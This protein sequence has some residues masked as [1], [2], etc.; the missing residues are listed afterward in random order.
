MGFYRA[1]RTKEEAEM[2][3]S[4]LRMPGASGM[5]KLPKYPRSVTVKYVRSFSEGKGAYCVYVY[6]K[7]VK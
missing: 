5:I 2:V 6:P 1:Y 3:A 7:E 4:E